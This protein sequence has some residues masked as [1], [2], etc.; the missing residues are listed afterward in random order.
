MDKYGD[1]HSNYYLCIVGCLVHGMEETVQAMPVGS[2]SPILLLYGKYSV[3]IPRAKGGSI[4]S[5]LFA[6]RAQNRGRN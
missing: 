4:N 6:P 2:D 5:T 1:F 3:F